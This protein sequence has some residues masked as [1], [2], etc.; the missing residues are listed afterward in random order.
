M[1]TSPFVPQCPQRATLRA[2]YF[3]KKPG[4]SQGE[5]GICGGEETEGPD[6]LNGAE[7]GEKHDSD[8]NAVAS[9]APA[10]AFDFL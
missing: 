4:K 9:K 7:N 10:T 2:G 3:S 5:T 1:F 8:K 6:R